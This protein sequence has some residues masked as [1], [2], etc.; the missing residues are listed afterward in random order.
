LGLLGRGVSAAGLAEL[1]PLF[2]LHMVTI[3]PIY[4]LLQSLVRVLKPR[5]VEF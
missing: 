2:V 5:R 3:L 1:T 4:L